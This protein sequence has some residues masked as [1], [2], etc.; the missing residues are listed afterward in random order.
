MLNWASQHYIEDKI[1]LNHKRA[2][3]PL[4]FKRFE[5]KHCQSFCELNLLVIL[6]H[7]STRIWLLWSLFLLSVLLF[8]LYLYYNIMTCTTGTRGNLHFVATFVRIWNLNSYDFHVV[9]VVVVLH[10]S[11]NFPHS[12][13]LSR[14]L[15]YDYGG[16]DFTLRI[17]FRID[18]RRRWWLCRCALGKR[19]DAV[20]LRLW[21][22]FW[23]HP[24][25]NIVE[26]ELLLPCVPNTL[27]E[28]CEISAS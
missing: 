16:Y 6:F 15:C 10:A 2:S 20:T 19:Q 3:A 18:V 22:S 4:H 1:S 21:L 11:L 12:P 28:I 13:R 14:L 24:N 27:S 8:S 5:F 23:R 9:L 17:R 7:L 25:Q 26:F